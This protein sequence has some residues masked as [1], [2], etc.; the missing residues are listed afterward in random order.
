MDRIHM[1]IYTAYIIAF[2]MSIV[3]YK[4]LRHV[5]S[6]NLNGDWDEILLKYMLMIVASFFAGFGFVSIVSLIV[7]LLGGIQKW[8]F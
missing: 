7:I 5:F 6:D 1:I 2:I 4:I 8:N 3:S